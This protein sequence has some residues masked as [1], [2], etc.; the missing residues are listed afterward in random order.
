MSEKKKIRLPRY[1]QVAIEIA[2][3]IVDNRYQVG[4][5]IHARSTLATTFGVSPETARKA[6]NILVDLNIMEVKHGS[7]VL[8]ASKSKAINY[9]EQY[10]DVQS[11]EETKTD[12]YASLE[13]QKQ[14]LSD[15]TS[16]VDQ[17]VSQT[18]KLN[19]VNPMLPSELVLTKEAEHLNTSISDLNLWQETSATVIAIL[20][21]EELVLSPG[22]YA[23]LNSGDTVYFVG[24]EFATQRM[25]NFFYPN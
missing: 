7:G 5:K 10:R 25:N 12:L 15:F 24:N 9:L 22:P 11:I 3:R 13:R 8:V 16:I 4:D 18:I 1:Q 20:H 6:V 19:K 2:E 14:E 17:L 23:V 21:K